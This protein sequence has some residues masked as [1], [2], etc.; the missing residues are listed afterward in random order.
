MSIVANDNIEISKL[1]LALVHVCFSKPMYQQ[2]KA[3][4]LFKLSATQSTFR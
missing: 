2:P 3:F 4:C 1:L